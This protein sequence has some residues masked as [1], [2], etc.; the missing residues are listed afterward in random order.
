MKELN[1]LILIAES[2]DAP[3]VEDEMIAEILLLELDNKSCGGRVLI[4]REPGFVAFVREEV[5]K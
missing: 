2:L 1:P 4:M 3:F 5:L